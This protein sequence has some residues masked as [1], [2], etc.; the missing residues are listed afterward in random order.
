MPAETRA[1]GLSLHRRIVD[2]V[3]GKILSGE[4]PPGR[5]IPFEHEL[6]ARFGCARMTVNKAITELARRGL[7]ERRRKL[8]SFVAPPPTQSAA[9]EIRDIRQE[10]DALGLPYRFERLART[11][12]AVSRGD[13]AISGLPPGARVLALTLRHR[14]GERPL[15]LEERIIDLAA[16]PEAATEPF[17]TRAPGPWL[18]ETIP[19]SRAEHRIRAETADARVA[20]LLEIAPGAACLVIERRTWSAD[21]FVTHA[22]LT[23]PG[24]RHELAAEF[25]PSG[26]AGERLQTTP[27]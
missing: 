6:T 17:E 15:C 16:A 21:A 23:Y 25:S 12:R 9:F 14:A 1:N 8:G 4:W 26:A 11:T 24:D 2:S 5:R 13:R 22:R 10:A 7:I 27:A 20:R 3:E 19:W 18:V